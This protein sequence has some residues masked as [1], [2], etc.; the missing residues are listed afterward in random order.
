MRWK[1]S[2]KLGKERIKYKKQSGVILTE[3]FAEA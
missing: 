1:G 2:L 3:P